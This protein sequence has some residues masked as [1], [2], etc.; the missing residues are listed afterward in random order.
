MSGIAEVLRNL[1]YEVSG[2]DQ[3]L[4]AA[5]DRLCRLGARIREGHDPEHVH[6][7]EAV[8]VS[9]AISPDNPEVLEARRLQIPLIPRGEMLAELMRLKFGIAV[10]GSHGK[11]TTT[12]MIGSVLATTLLDPTIVVGGRLNSVAGSARLGKGEFM[13]VESDESDRSFLHLAP[14]LAIITSIDRE[15][16]DCYGDLRDL[17]HAFVKFANKVPFYGASIVC[18]ADENIRSI[19][20]LLRRRVVSYGTR[21]ADLF[22][23]NIQCGHHAS[24]YDLRHRGESL[25]TV[26]LQLPGRHN[27]MN[28]LAAVAVGL[29][30]NIEPEKIRRGLAEFQ[31]VERRFQLRGAAG[32]VAVVDDYAHHPSEIRA[33]LSAARDCD[34]QRILVLFQPHRYSR[35][36]ALLEEFAGAFDDADQVHVLDIFGAGEKALP[37]VHAEKVVEAIHA[38][39]GPPVSY[40]PETQAL[41]SRVA[42]QV[43][44][45]DLVLTLGAGSVWRLGA[46]LLEILRQR[47]PVSLGAGRAEQKKGK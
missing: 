28:S 21:D 15:H 37:G 47:D 4:S 29:E 40:E 20:G 16:L 12:S 6:G 3:R 25:G 41:L 24:S 9:S 44:P 17:Q 39:G 8:V 22:A 32:G 1:D 31:G 10:A 46:Q 18:L 5:T 43:K 45:G 7:A 36:A 13:V 42:E 14:I 23:E 30:L 19:H 27:V 38:R 33:T 35:T 26:C 11:T 34:Y 2:S